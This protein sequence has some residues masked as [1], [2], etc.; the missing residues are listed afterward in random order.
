MSHQEDSIDFSRDLNQ[1][2]E[3]SFYKGVNRGKENLEQRAVSPIKEEVDAENMDHTLKEP[4]TSE[5]KSISEHYSDTFEEAQD[6]N[7]TFPAED[8]KKDKEQQKVL[9]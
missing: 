2:L 6:L 7:A 4:K 3:D 9:N 1:P 5:K 8:L